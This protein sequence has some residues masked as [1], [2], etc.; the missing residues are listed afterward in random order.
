MHSQKSASESLCVP[1]PHL[2]TGNCVLTHLLLPRLRISLIGPRNPL[3]TAEL[4]VIT[5]LGAA[6]LLKEHHVRLM[7]GLMISKVFY[8]LNNSLIP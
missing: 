4:F 8:S 1:G 6:G 2:H 3:I 7:V 5:V